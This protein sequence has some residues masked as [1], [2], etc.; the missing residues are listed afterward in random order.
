M[1]SSLCITLC[2]L[3]VG[4]GILTDCLVGVTA[5]YDGLVK[6]HYSC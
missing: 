1:P 4:K 6:S 2:H 3:V 5:A